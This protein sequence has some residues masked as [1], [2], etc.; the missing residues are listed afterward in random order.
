MNRKIINDIRMPAG[1]R[2]SRLERQKE[3]SD[4]LKGKYVPIKEVVPQNNR[5]P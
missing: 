3:A 4:T 1:E 2:G 5:R